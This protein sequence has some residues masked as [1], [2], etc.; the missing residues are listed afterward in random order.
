LDDSQHL[1]VVD[2]IVSLHWVQRLGQEGDGVPC[3]VVDLLLGEDRTGSDAV[4][5]G[6]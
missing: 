1:S 3:V 6:L 2:L 4:A 5:V